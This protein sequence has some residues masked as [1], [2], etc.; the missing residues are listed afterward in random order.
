MSAPK[1]TRG[2]RL[3]KVQLFAFVVLVL[4]AIFAFAQKVGAQD[5][6]PPKKP[7]AGKLAPKPPAEKAEPKDPKHGA[8]A[9]GEMGTAAEAKPEA[10]AKEKAGEDKEDET[11][12]HV[13]EAVLGPKGGVP[14]HPTGDFRSPFANPKHGTT[15]A[16]VG[17][18]LETIEDYD[19]KK[20]AFTAHF[21]VSLTSETPM[22]KVDLQAT[23]GKIE[24]RETLADLPTFKIFKFAG[25]FH[26]PPDLHAYPFD[27]QEL[28]IELEDD[29]NGIDAL[30]LRTDVDHSFLDSDFTVPGWDVAYMRARI[31]NHYYPDRFESDD[32]YYSKYKFT[33]G[34]KRFA[35]SAVFTVFVP[36]LVI[37]MISLSGLWFPRDELEVRSNATTPMLAAAVLFHFALMQE[38]PATA[39]L[40]RADKLMMSVYACLGLHMLSSWIWF[41]FDEKHTERIFKLAKWICAPITFVVMACGILL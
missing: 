2:R 21:F 36:A 25:T 8:E 38:L 32:L 7:G 13:K 6:P 18:L 3:H 22:P 33:V 10:H 19:I 26:T 16:K 23:N 28:V 35:T 30:R 9:K 34:I 24:E 4:V 29:S 5:A 12:E 39:Y 41:V 15:V 14:T 20:G 1:Q 17:F 37:V 11:S 27:T 40:S 31:L